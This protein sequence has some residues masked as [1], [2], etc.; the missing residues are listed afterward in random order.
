M[1]R[2]SQKIE[3]C[4]AEAGLPDD[5]ELNQILRYDAR[6]SNRVFKN[7]HELQRLQANRLNGKPVATSAVDVTLT[8]DSPILDD[9]NPDVSENHNS[10]SVRECLEAGDITAADKVSLIDQ[11]TMTQEEQTGN[12]ELVQNVNDPV[13]SG[14]QGNRNKGIKLKDYL[15]KN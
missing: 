7:L 14:L 11:S 10:P 12:G 5:A 2:I 1:E 6:I 13:R 3:G 9:S 4:K 8:V 15:G